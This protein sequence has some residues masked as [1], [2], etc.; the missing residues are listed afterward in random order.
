MNSLNP[1]N[2][3]I[4]NS[5]LGDPLSLGQNQSIPNGL[6][7]VNNKAT[8][9]TQPLD[10]CNVVSSIGMV[11]YHFP[12]HILN[13]CSIYLI[14]S[15]ISDYFASINSFYIKIYQNFYYYSLKCLFCSM[16]LIFFTI[17]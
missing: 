1:V 12:L 4:P 13:L 6:I 3:N 14:L 17:I 2:H 10:N 8:V 15:S 7:S 16:A 11:I 5:N 9:S